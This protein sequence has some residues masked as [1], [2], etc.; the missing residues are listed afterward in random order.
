MFIITFF[1]YTCFNSKRI[2]IHV[3]NSTCLRFK[4]VKILLHFMC[5]V[6]CLGPKHIFYSVAIESMYNSMCD[7]DN[8]TE[9]FPCK[10]IPKFAPKI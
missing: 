6:K 7:D 9:T 10:S 8:I 1:S 4:G 3:T 5:L 2:Q